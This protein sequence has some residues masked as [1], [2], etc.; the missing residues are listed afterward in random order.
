MPKHITRLLLVIVLAAVL[1]YVGKQWLT[2]ESFYRFGHYRG[3]SVAEIA[4]DKPKYATPKSCETC[5]AAKYAEWSRG[6]HNNPEQGKVVKCEVCH[7]AAGGRD[8]NPNGYN[9]ATGAEHPKNLKLEIPADTV[10]QCTLCHEQMP[11]RPLQQKQIVVAT[12]AGTQQCKVCHNVHS[13]RTFVGALASTSKPGNPAAGKAIAADCAACHGKLGISEDAS[14][15]SLAGQ[16]EIYLADAIKA[17]KKGLRKDETMMSMA[18]DLS[19]SASEN[20][21]AYFA[22]L[23]CKSAQDGETP[24]AARGQVL[25]KKCASCHGENGISKQ[26]MWPSLAG[27]SKPYLEK[28]LKSYKAERK[29]GMMN[30]IAKNMS[31]ADMADLASYYANVACR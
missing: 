31:D 7:G 9:S 15:P 12:H 25:A 26:A 24:A 22:S 8:K 13:P 14:I 5:H 19:D 20:L 28:A 10:R 27:L 3:N 21:A 18:K 11:G 2:V 16:T 30:N 1:A 29:N 17:Y 4:S 6:V 23:T